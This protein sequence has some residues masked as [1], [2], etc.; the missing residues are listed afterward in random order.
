[1]SATKQD[2]IDALLALRVNRPRHLADNHIR[3]LLRT[4]GGSALSVA[5]LQA[6]R[7]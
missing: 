7:S 4:Y 5:D 1:M 3:T 6:A 2:V